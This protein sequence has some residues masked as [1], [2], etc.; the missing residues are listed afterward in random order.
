MYRKV[1]FI[2]SSPKVLP[3][4]KMCLNIYIAVSIALRPNISLSETREGKEHLL[5]SIVSNFL[6][7][8]KYGP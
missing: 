1:S 6:W 5:G 4:I 8:E 2:E 7:R 3:K